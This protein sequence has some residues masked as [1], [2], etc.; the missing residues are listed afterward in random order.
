MEI[1]EIDQGDESL[2]HRHWEIGRD[3][4]A[5]YRPYDFYVQWETAWTTYQVGRED[6]RFVLLGAFDGDTMVGAGRTDVNLLDNLH[7]ASSLIFVDP[8]RQRQ[9]IGRALD[10]ACVEVARAEGPP[11]ADD[12]GLRAPRRR[13]RRGAVRPRRWATRRASRT[14]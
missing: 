14:A 5:A 10:A 7:S 3:A 12:R 6:L 1:R 4:E 11:R 13:L 8:A 2:V 9:G